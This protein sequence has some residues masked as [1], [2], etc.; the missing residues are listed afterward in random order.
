MSCRVKE[1]AHVKCFW[2][3]FQKSRLIVTSATVPSMRRPAL[4]TMAR[5]QVRVHQAH[6][7]LASQLRWGFTLHSRQDAR[8]LPN[9]STTS[10]FSAPALCADRFIP[11]P[12]CCRC[13]HNL[14]PC[15][16]ARAS[17]QREGFFYGRLVVHM[18]MAC[19]A[20]HRE[21]ENRR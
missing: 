18:R 1:D 14:A 5:H 10:P 11:A 15:A 19:L 13:A 2:G 8:R 3:P 16:K 6:V 12:R 4:A 20:T 9:V 7:F 17:S 21:R